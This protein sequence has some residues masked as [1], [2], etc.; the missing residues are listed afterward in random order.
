[1][2]FVY[3]CCHPRQPSPRLHELVIKANPTAGDRQ[4][5]N[6]RGFGSRLRFVICL[7]S[8]VCCHMFVVI[9]LYQAPNSRGKHLIMGSTN[10][11]HEY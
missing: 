2:S 8:Y 1:M 5:L 9:C 11:E 10:R 3:L 7:L 6:S 4:Y